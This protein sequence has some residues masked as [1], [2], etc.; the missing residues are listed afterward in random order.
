MSQACRRVGVTIL[1]WMKWYCCGPC[2]GA[3]FCK[4]SYPRADDFGCSVGGVAQPSSATVRVDMMVVNSFPTGLGYRHLHRWSELLYQPREDSAL[5]PP[6][7]QQNP[8]GGGVPPQKLPLSVVSR[9]Q[10]PVPV[11][12]FIG[13]FICRFAHFRSELRV[14]GTKEVL[15]PH[16]V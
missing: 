4:T 16:S 5:S 2:P 3:D 10:L 1:G 8:G 6:L 7:L 12:I 11:K 9:S 13:Y 15:L 14:L